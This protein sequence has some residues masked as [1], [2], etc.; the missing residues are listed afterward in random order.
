MKS[1]ELNWLNEKKHYLEDWKVKFKGAKDVLPFVEAN[2]V[3]TDWAIEA[4]R[5]Q[6]TTAGE[7]P[8]PGLVEKL[9]RDY[10]YTV[11][12]LPPVPVYDLTRLST[13][14]SMATSGTASVYDYV[15]G[16]GRYGTPEARRYAQT[17]ITKYDALQEAQHR[18]QQTRIQVEKLKSPST[19]DR[20]DRAGTSY[21]D[22]KSGIV[23]PTQA[24]SEIRNLLYA[25]HG[26]LLEMARK[27]QKEPM[28][29]LKMAKRLAKPGPNDGP[30]QELAAQ[31]DVYKTLT[32]RLSEM[33]KDRRHV[34]SEELN[35]TWTQVLDH[36]YTI[37]GLVN[38]P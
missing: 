33:A 10:H 4:L 28:T 7:Q 23:A 19:L 25:I 6:P 5:N 37:L 30:Y 13:A 29:W 15:R 18:P 34:S 11:D 20:F 38:L 8:F 36:I 1:E 14:S 24:T 31:G 32:N 26:N 12:A 17:Y 35:Q 27:T 16:F 2:I 9:E 21:V 3:N 22:A